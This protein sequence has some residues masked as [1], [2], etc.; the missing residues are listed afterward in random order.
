MNASRLVA[1]FL[2]LGLM[3]A[4][5]AEEAP[6][7]S[8]T[9]A[10]EPAQAAESTTPAE[11]P[12]AGYT[13]LSIAE[14]QELIGKED[15]TLVNVHVPFEGDLPETDRSIPFDQIEAHLDQ[16]PAD[17]NAPVVLYCRSGRMSEIAG[18]TLAGL[19]YSRVYNLVGG[20]NAWRAA[21]LPMA[22]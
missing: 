13:D 15:V 4:C 8:T 3:V 20:F 10:S 21:G 6:P 7:S 9:T 16:L 19:G 1:P 14:F 11:A 5:G 2:A 18:G 12:E 22:Q 17:R